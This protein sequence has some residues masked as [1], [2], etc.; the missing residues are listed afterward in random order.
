MLIA[1]LALIPGD[2][3]KCDAGNAAQWHNYCAGSDRILPN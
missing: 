3:R 1:M 2:M